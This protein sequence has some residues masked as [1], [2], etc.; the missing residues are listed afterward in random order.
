MSD[1]RNRIF[2]EELRVLAENYA[3]VCIA[4]PAHCGS[5][6]AA[7]NLLE[8]F[9]GA[10]HIIDWEQFPSLKEEIC[11]ISNS[12]R[13]NS[14]FVISSSSLPSRDD[15]DSG[16]N[17]LNRVRT[18]V[19]STFSMLELGLS[20]GLIS[21]SGLFDSDGYM[22][23]L[24][25]SPISVSDVFRF[26]V[27]GGWPENFRKS[28]SE[29]LDFT[30]SYLREL[31]SDIDETNKK[32]KTDKILN[33]IRSIAAYESETESLS[34]W[35]RN[36][37]GDGLSIS[38]NTALAYIEQLRNKLILTTQPAFVPPQSAELSRYLIAKPKTRF[39]DPSLVA[40]SN[41]IRSFSDVESDPVTLSKLFDSLCTHELMVYA[42]CI[43]GAQVCH[44]C[45]NYS[46]TADA[47]IML[48]DSRW[49]AFNFALT[50]EHIDSAAVNLLKLS[51]CFS[52]IKYRPVFTAVIC[53][54]G[55]EAYIRK[56]GIL[57]LPLTAIG[58]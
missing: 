52:D 36:A 12:T 2:D 27:R 39:A 9:P 8:S 4:G 18:K 48:P 38:R 20:S 7:R 42:G 46:V 51:S 58:P 1:Y 57:V 16:E 40:A 5:S 22:A 43:E 55:D 25:I 47:V 33:L 17:E 13:H 53:G 3:T 15:R 29:A 24:S 28:D 50:P 23:P 19:I 44:Y 11:N 14:L 30:R 49:A 45:D 35:L 34:K 31:A 32:T 21:I 10:S 6:T 26:I 56:D 54:T 37:S 41:N